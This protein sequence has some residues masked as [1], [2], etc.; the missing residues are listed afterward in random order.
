M[1]LFDFVFRK[2]ILGGKQ[3]LYHILQCSFDKTVLAKESFKNYVK[4]IF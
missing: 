3:N 1:I 4:Q 2:I